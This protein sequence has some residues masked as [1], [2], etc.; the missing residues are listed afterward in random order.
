[1][2]AATLYLASDAAK[3]VTGA[4]FTLDGGYTAI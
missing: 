4:E 2:A 3:W 1:V